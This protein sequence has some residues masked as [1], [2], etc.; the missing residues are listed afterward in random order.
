MIGVI[1][2]DFIVHP[3]MRVMINVAFCVHFYLNFC[4][5]SENVEL[6]YLIR[7]LMQSRSQ[8]G[9]RGWFWGHPKTPQNFP[10]HTKKF[11]NPSLKKFLATPLY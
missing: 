7:L 10:F 4:I 9:E 2:P 1:N 6:E 8:G 3:Q 5:F 11:Q